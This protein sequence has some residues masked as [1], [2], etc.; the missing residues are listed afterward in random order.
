LNELFRKLR[1]RLAER[2]EGVAD[3]EPEYREFRQ[4]DVRHSLADISIA[5]RFLGYR[6]THSLDQGL[7]EAMDWYLAAL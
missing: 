7:D 4:G 2:V 6:P 5:R 3:V 1:D